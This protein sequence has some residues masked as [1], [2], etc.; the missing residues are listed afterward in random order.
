MLNKTNILVIFILFIIGCINLPETTADKVEE[1]PAATV[2]IDATVDAKVEAKIKGLTPVSDG[3]T[4]EIKNKSLANRIK[5]DA[6]NKAATKAVENYHAS[7]HTKAAINQ[8]KRASKTPDDGANLQQSPIRTPTPVV[9]SGDYP[10]T[11]ICT[12]KDGSWAD[13]IKKESPYKEANI[14]QPY[15]DISGVTVMV[16]SVMQNSGA[17]NNVFLQYSL[18]NNTSNQIF[19]E[20]SFTLYL[21]DGKSMPQYGFFNE[22][23]P[24]QQISRNYTWNMPSSQYGIRVVYS[25]FDTWGTPLEELLGWDIP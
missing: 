13:C 25:S 8:V 23:V 15:V 9:C 19:N 1:S 22:L 18:Q 17:I 5:T 12:C 10:I 16:N 24:G 2:D 7:L 3:S 21:N 6:S 20:G 14:G 11:L 4:S